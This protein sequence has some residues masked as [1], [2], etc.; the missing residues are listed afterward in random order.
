MS[1]PSK[2]EK[3]RSVPDGNGPP[4]ATVSW[5]ASIMEKKLQENDGTKPCWLE[6][7]RDFVARLEE[8]LDE[9]VDAIK[10]MDMG[11]VVLEAAD[12]ACMAMMIAD[13]ARVLVGG[14]PYTRGKAEDGK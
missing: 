10:F 6:E 4:R 8:E 9:L 7:Q 5:F 11:A 12:V 2:V 14:I 3:Q 13:R 1:A